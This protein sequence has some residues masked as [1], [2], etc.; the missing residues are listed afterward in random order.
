MPI[1]MNTS[2]QYISAIGLQNSAKHNDLF[3]YYNQVVKL[4]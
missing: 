4:E 2:N 3:V 1:Q